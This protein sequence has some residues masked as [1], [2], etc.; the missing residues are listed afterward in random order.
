MTEEK[1][2]VVYEYK[3][4]EIRLVIEE[5]WDSDILV[6]FTISHDNKYVSF[7]LNSKP[8]SNI[9]F[10]VEDG[11]LNVI[12]PD[13]FPT[14]DEIA[15]I[16]FE[17]IQL[18]ERKIDSKRKERHGKINTRE[19]HV[20]TTCFEKTIEMFIRCSYDCDKVWYYCREGSAQLKHV[21][22][23]EAVFVIG[24]EIEKAKSHISDSIF[25]DKSLLEQL[26][27][28]KEIL[29][30]SSRQKSLKKKYPELHKK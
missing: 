3:G 2:L 27:N 29:R 28:M 14:L 30:E 15:R 8:K 11:D 17:K 24:E 13:H 10:K 6:N 5:E 12:M 25:E 22:F 7:T 23:N 1:Y 21:P 4:E 20:Y 16:I 26:K 18:E 19:L 9:D